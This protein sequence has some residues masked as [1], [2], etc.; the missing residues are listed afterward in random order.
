MLGL[1]ATNGRRSSLLRDKSGES[2]LILHADAKLENPAALLANRGAV[3]VLQLHDAKGRRR[4]E[5]LVDDAGWSRLRVIG[6]GGAV[7]NLMAAHE[8]GVSFH[9]LDAKGE[10]RVAI[11]LGEGTAGLGLRDGRARVLTGVVVGPKKSASLFVRDEDGDSLFLVST[12]RDGALE[13]KLPPTGRAP[14]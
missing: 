6:A 8:G 4:S 10:D 14:R 5:I 11:Q 2:S 3:R 13:T 1:T 7:A 9:G 12:D